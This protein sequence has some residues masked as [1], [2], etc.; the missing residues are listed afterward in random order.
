M[1]AALAALGSVYLAADKLWT[2][3]HSVTVQ[4]SASDARPA[5]SAASVVVAAAFN[6]PP[7]SIAVLPFVNLSGDKEQDYFSDGLTE[8]LLNSLSR[9]NE[10]QVAA[11]TSS[12]F[13]K[14]KDV[15]LGTITHKLNVASVLEGSVRR[16]GRIVRIT[17]QLN[18]AATGFHLWSQSYDRDLGDVLQLQAEIADAV[19]NALKVTLLGDVA[20]RVELG[21]TRNPAAFDAYLRGLKAFHMVHNAQDEEAAIA[22]YAEA[23]G[24]DPNYAIARAARSLAL[25]DYAN[26]YATGA[27]ISA[28]YETAKSDAQLAIARAPALGDGYLALA[29][30]L[31]S[32]SLD[33]THAAEHFERARALAPGSAEVAR[34]YG[35]FSA[36]LGHT[37]AALAAARRAVQLDPLNPAM[38]RLLSFVLRVSRRYEEAVDAAQAAVDL[39]AEN[40]RALT[41]RG[42][43]YY[44]AGDYQRARASCESA[45]PA[46][47]PSGDFYGIL[48][49]LA[50]SYEKLGRHADAEAMLTRL[51]SSYGDRVAYQHAEIYAQWDD[52]PKAL[53]WLEKAIRLRDPGVAILKVDPLLD[54]VRNEPRFQSIQQALTFPP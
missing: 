44:D 14:G 50:L 43:A 28:S 2:S 11:R 8:E 10:L 49:C 7:H 47:D 26:N 53:A 31:E 1:V 35:H 29:S 25:T 40:P 22:V 20:A 6:P 41:T 23:I 36:R 19:A 18:N 9:I 46:A 52:A 33:L 32:E 42:L 21:G 48:A 38:Y 45:R 34:R 4:P 30:L 15:D 24:L 13:F 51:Q 39:D 17:A 27:T 37:D 54:P 12:F 5:A 16:S 3:R